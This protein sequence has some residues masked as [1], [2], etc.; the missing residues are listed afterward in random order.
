MRARLAW[1][2]LILGATLAVLG[3]AVMV[4]LGPDSR[5][6]TGPHAVKT[7]GAAVVTAPG[8][9][10]YRGLQ[11]DVMAELPASKPVF[12]GVG[13]TV[14]VQ[15]YVAQTQRLEVTSFTVPW[16]ATSKEI[17]GQ[18]V[19]PGAPTALDWWIEDSA[20][21]GGASVS[22]TLP[23][24]SVSVAIL[25]VG[26]SNLSGLTVTFAYG[27]KGGFAQGL[28]GFL[29]GAGLLWCGVLMRRAEPLEDDGA[30]WDSEEWDADADPQPVPSEA[31]D[32]VVED[33]VYV[34]IDEH[35]VEHEISE[36][37]AERLQA[38]LDSDE[39]EASTSDAH[40]EPTEQSVAEA[41][42]PVLPPVPTAAAIV[43]EGEGPPASAPESTPS[44]AAEDV[45]YLYVD[46]DGVEHVL[47]ADELADHEPDEDGE[48]R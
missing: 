45:V 40:S 22:V 39:T 44:P 6:T 14:H 15:N 16:T 19:L 30:E 25:S 38:E 18:P 46:D 10:S 28:G 33:V 48:D 8:V 23:D 37:E 26:T 36:E 27:V 2:A 3:L 17:K 20:G 12:V 42:G 31:D 1:V 35:G 7:T 21:L 24:E 9:V 13:N 5:L 11:V 43:A 47:S 32:E 34:Y 4:V 29:A 41:A